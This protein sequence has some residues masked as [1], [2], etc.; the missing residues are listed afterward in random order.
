MSL[1]NNNI[2]AVLNTFWAIYDVH[3]VANSR[4]TL[5]QTDRVFPELAVRYC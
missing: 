2:P 3:G 1:V 5:V 4:Y